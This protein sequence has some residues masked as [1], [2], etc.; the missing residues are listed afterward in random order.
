M[1]SRAL[2]FLEANTSSA[3]AQLDRPVKDSTEAL[4]FTAV[5]SDKRFVNVIIIKEGPGN[6]VDKH[7]YSAKAMADGVKAF[8][9]ARAC[10]NHQTAEEADARPEQDVT[11]LCGYYRNTQLLKGVLNEKLGK[12]VTAVG[13]EFVPTPTEAGDMAFGLAKAQ[14]IWQQTFP[15]RVGECVRRPEH[16]FRR[17]VRR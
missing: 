14:V 4:A 12:L 3:V 13:A 10:L 1:R 11:Q 9:G 7:W 5:N 15:D 2:R 6:D 16:Q 8:E 17:H